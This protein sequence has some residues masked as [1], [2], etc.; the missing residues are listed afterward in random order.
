[1]Q[2]T[3][4]PC[5]EIRAAQLAIGMRGVRGSNC[6]AAKDFYAAL[7]QTVGVVN[8]LWKQTEYK[9]LADWT[10][11]AL[12]GSLLQT[13]TH[14]GQKTPPLLSSWFHS[15]SEL[16]IYRPRHIILKNRQQA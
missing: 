3:C 5:L 7:Q 10:G 2:R 8:V 13:H 6:E 4:K 1:M 9:W 16:L 15:I 12:P 11:D 14:T